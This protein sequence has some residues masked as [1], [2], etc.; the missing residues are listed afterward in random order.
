M[1]RVK[2]GSKSRKA[3][4]VQLERLRSSG[5]MFLQRYF[6]ENPCEW[7]SDDMKELN[8]A[9][10]VRIISSDSPEFLPSLT[11]T[12]LIHGVFRVLSQRPKWAHPSAVLIAIEQPYWCRVDR[13][14]LG[15]YLIKI[16]HGGSQIQSVSHNFFMY[17]NYRF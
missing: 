4:Q 12:M 11:F 8:H 3:I 9:C 17:K 7:T 15:T 16:E 2:W 14:L 6:C 5:T 10:Q 1:S 13:Q